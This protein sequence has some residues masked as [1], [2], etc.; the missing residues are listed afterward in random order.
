MEITVKNIKKVVKIIKE[1]R[2]CESQHALED[3]LH[4]HFI[5]YIASLDIPESVLAKEVLKT[6]KLDFERWCA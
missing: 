3:S 6:E 5:K 1:S 4:V 2:D